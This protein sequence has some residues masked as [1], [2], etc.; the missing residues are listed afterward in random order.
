MDIKQFSTLLFEIEVNGHIAHLQTTSFSQ[1]MALDELYRGMVDVRDK[2]IEDYQGQNK[3]VTGYSNLQ[4]IEGADMIKYLEEKRNL[5]FDFRE[6]ITEGF[7]QQ[8]IDDILSL[9][10]SVLYKLK[11]LS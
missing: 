6:T 7:L 1:H 4:I 8:D 2:F 11:N 9:I 5:I 3:I 10:S